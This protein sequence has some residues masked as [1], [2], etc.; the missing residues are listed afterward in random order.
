[1]Q[2]AHQTILALLAEQRVGVLGSSHNGHP[3]ASLVAFFADDEGRNIYFVTTRATRKYGNL[4]D[5]SRVSFLVDNRQNRPDDLVEACAI[6][7]YGDAEELLPHEREDAIVRF[8]ARHPQL[9]DF[10][11]SPSSA[12]F[13]IRVDSY[14]LVRHFQQVTEFRFQT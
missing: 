12:M 9:H 7:A 6:T 1:M 13:R 5:D 11:R 14:H 4:H 10:A 3:Y 8:L 2:T